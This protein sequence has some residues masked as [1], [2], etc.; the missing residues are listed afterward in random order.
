MRWCESVTGQPHRHAVEGGCRRRLTPPA[1]LPCPMLPRLAAPL[2]RFRR[3]TR[4]EPECPVAAEHNGWSDG[5]S[6]PQILPESSLPSQLFLPDGKLARVLTKL[7]PDVERTSRRT[8]S[9]R[10]RTARLDKVI[11]L[12]RLLRKLLANLAQRLSVEP[13]PAG[14]VRYRHQ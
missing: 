13:A 3:P 2:Q 4:R 8:C 11:A 14:L 9:S 5:R 7:V 1:L 12:R 10:D 6:F